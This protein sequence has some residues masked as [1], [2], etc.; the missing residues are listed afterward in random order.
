[1]IHRVKEE[2]E[3]LKAKFKNAKAENE[4]ARRRELQH[5]SQTKKTALQQRLEQRKL[6]L[7]RNKERE[8]A[9]KARQAKLEEMRKAGKLLEPQVKYKI[10]EKEVVVEKEVEREVIEKV[11]IGQRDEDIAEQQR[12]REGVRHAPTTRVVQSIELSCFP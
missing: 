2:I 5:E 12:L 1:M 10:V 7:Q 6:Q 9:E 4:R 8:E 3:A 11:I